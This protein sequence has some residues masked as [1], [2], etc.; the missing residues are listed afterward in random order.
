MNKK[1]FTLIEVLFVMVLVAAISVTVG[2]NMSGMQVRQDEKQLENYNATLT[3]AGCVYA[4]MKNIT[5]NTEVTVETLIN[6]GLISK[7][8]KIPNTKKTVESDKNKIV[9]IK[10]TNNEKKCTLKTS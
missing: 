1:G 3:K 7:N 2:V 6:A 8:L 10:W 9:V 4:E 5:S